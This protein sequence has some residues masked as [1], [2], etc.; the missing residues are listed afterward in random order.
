MLI[1]NVIMLLITSVP[2]AT[3]AATT[4]TTGA[5][6]T[7]GTT[8]AVEGLITT[9]AGSIIAGIVIGALIITVTVGACCFAMR[10][11]RR[12]IKY[13]SAGMYQFTPNEIYNIREQAVH[14]EGGN[15]ESPLQSSAPYYDY[16]ENNDLTIARTVNIQQ[17][18]DYNFTVQKNVAYNESQQNTDGPPSTG[19]DDSDYVVSSYYS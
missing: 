15:S 4:S 17:S 1:S 10:K 11:R 7:I 6:T 3:V 12:H 13:S 2:D 5:T 9:A 16:I 14:N 8:A 18:E 19:D